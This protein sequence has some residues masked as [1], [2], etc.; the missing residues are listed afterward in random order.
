MELMLELAASLDDSKF[1]LSPV[2]SYQTPHS[3]PLCSAD[4]ID[5]LVHVQPD[6]ALMLPQSRLLPRLLRRGVH[7]PREDCV[8][9]K[10]PLN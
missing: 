6:T 1:E 9:L 5:F 7:S 3:Y 10:S 4:S 2:A 8:P